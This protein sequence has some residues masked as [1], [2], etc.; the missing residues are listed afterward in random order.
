MQHFAPAVTRAEPVRADKGTALHILFSLH[1]EELYD[2]AEALGG[3]RGVRLVSRLDAQLRKATE[4]TRAARQ[5]AGELVRLLM[6]DGVDGLESEEAG[7]FAQIDPASELV[8]MICRL[9]DL[10]LDA[11]SSIERERSQR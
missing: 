9:T 2:A 6:L 11:L 7:H 3:P 10:L 1:G 8:H 5:L 4:V